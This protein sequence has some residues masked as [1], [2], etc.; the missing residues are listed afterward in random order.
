M[1]RRPVNVPLIV[2]G[3]LGIILI[4]FLASFIYMSLNGKD[5]SSNYN[6]PTN[7]LNGNSSSYETINLLGNKTIVIEANNINYTLPE[8]E[9]ELIN[10]TSIILKLYNLH[11]IPF[12]SIPPKIQV[13]IDN[14]D[15]FI[16]VINGNIIINNGNVDSPDLVINTTSANMINIQQNNTP[17]QN[18]IS[19]GE[20]SIDMT[21]NKFILF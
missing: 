4:G 14:N 2:L 20:I 8:I 13:Y 9:E 7:L 16:E 21:A 15:Y 19:S 5:Y 17:I 6:S 3:I 10:Y 1:E 18:A 12:T 11:N